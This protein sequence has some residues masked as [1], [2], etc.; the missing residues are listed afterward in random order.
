MFVV[1]L[2]TSIASVSLRLLMYIHYCRYKLLREDTYILL[3]KS[4]LF[5]LPATSRVVLYPWP[6]LTRK[7]LLWLPDGVAVS[8]QLWKGAG[9]GHKFKRAQPKWPSKGI[10]QHWGQCWQGAGPAGEHGLCSCVRSWYTC[11]SQGK[12]LSLK[13]QY[14]SSWIADGCCTHVH[15]CRKTSTQLL[16]QQKASSSFQI[17]RKTFIA[18][19]L[20]SGHLSTITRKS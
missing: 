17:W 1:C 11:R 7:H 12:S 20:I 4:C 19:H 13:L 14:M 10:A 5:F 15:T 3:F 2:T 18:Y 9:L 16:C 6:V 8:A